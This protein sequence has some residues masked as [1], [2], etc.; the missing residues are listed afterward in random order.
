MYIHVMVFF[1]IYIFLIL[2]IGYIIITGVLR[3]F[4]SSSSWLP[5]A[6]AR[7]RGSLG[8]DS[9]GSHGRRR[10]IPGK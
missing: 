1:P 3:I 7:S 10:N 8:S 9:T 5:D 4:L 2:K 6:A